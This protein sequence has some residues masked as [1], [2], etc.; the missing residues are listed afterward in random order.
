MKKFFADT[1]KEIIEIEMEAP[2]IFSKTRESLQTDGFSVK[3][4]LTKSNVKVVCTT[5]DPADS[6]EHHIR[7]Q[8]DG[9][10]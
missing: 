7:I 1:I 10:F 6:L 8:L 4:L 5:D 9:N 3:S 2:D